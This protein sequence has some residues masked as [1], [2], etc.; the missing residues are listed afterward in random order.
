MSPEPKRADRLLQ[1]LMVGMMVMVAIAVVSIWYVVKS[2]PRDAVLGDA[3]RSTVSVG[4]P[5]TLTD[6]NGRTITDQSFNGLYRLIYFGYTFCPDACPTELQIM[7]Q[8][9][10]DLG[11][12]G[13][14]VQPIFITVDPE[15]DTIKQLAGYVP[16]FH[17]RLVGLTGTP[18]QIGAVEKAFKVYAAKAEGEKGGPYMMNHSSFVYLQ[19]PDGKFITVFPADMDAEKMAAEIGKYMKASS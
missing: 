1:F 14:K 16:A 12:A 10:D 13:D 5:Y 9:I 15:R 7:S 8:A 4:G 17:K 19:G 18:E 2:G 11:A 3:A 6:E